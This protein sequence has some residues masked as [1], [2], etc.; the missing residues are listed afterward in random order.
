MER[1]IAVATF[2]PDDE[3]ET[4]QES[5]DELLLLGLL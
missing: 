2:W 5:E 3:K 4:P 1:V